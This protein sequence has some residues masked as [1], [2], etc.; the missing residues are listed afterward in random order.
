MN[1]FSELA[2]QVLDTAFQPRS[3]LLRAINSQIQSSGFSQGRHVNL[4]DLRVRP[5]IAQQE[6]VLVLSKCGVELFDFP[7]IPIK[8]RPERLPGPCHFILDRS[9]QLNVTF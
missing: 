7:T 3:R 1:C 4:G 9:N 2:T 5:C 6:I 8:T